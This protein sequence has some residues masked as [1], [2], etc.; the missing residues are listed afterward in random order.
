MKALGS[1]GFKSNKNIHI[2]VFVF[3]LKDEKSII[4]SSLLSEVMGNGP[5]MKWSTGSNRLQRCAQAVA[6]APCLVSILIIFS[7]YINN[8]H[9][10]FKGFIV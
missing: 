9:L 3:S 5:N 4:M 8:N 7:F 10:L 6:N 1:L 2:F